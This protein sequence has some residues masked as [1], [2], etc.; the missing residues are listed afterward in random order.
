MR[1]TASYRLFQARN[2]N[3]V[4]TEWAQKLPDFVRRLEDALYRTAASKVWQ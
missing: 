1:G 4:N 2:Q 3:N